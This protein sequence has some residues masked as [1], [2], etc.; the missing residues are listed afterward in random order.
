MYTIK[1]GYR[2][3]LIAA[4]SNEVVVS[5]KRGMRHSKMERLVQKAEQDC[6]A[7]FDICANWDLDTDLGIVFA[8]EFDIPFISSSAIV[9][10]AR[11]RTAK[12]RITIEYDATNNIA[13]IY[14]AVTSAVGFSDSEAAAIEWDCRKFWV[15]ADIQD[16]FF[17][18]VQAAGTNDFC[19]GAAWMIAGPK[20]DKTLPKRTVRM[21]YGFFRNRE[22][23]DEE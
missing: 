21:E 12:G 2:D 18:A 11:A 15:S 3:G 13:E 17:A 4:L 19:A 23:G 14:K 16:D 6:K 5:L 20:T 10:A 1:E 7:P 22:G 9:S 8:T